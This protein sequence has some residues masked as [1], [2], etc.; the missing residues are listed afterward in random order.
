MDI[1][2][3][4]HLSGSTYIYAFLRGEKIMRK[5]WKGITKWMAIFADEGLFR[6]PANR[7][8]PSPRKAPLSS[9]SHI[10]LETFDFYEAFPGPCFRVLSLILAIVYGIGYLIE[11][12]HNV[13]L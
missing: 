1:F 7:R 13:E 12:T 8:K 4:Q 10:I 11:F 9:T 3:G 5:S 2:L 6:A